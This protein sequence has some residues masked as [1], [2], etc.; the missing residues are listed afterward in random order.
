MTPHIGNP[1]PG[2]TDDEEEKQEEP[3]IEE[4]EAEVK[5]LKAEK[6]RQRRQQ[7]QAEIQSLRADVQRPA[8]VDDRMV[9]RK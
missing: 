8:P 1:I 3:S 6:E 7:L 5:R 4:M 2:L 9:V